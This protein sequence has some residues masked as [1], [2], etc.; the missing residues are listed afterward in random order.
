MHQAKL[1]AQ[2]FNEQTLLERE[3][4]LPVTSFFVYQGEKS[5]LNSQIFFTQQFVLPLFTQIDQVFNTTYA[6][7]ADDNQKEIKKRLSEL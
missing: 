6:L 3:N 4:N 5:F 1:L 2:E 7:V